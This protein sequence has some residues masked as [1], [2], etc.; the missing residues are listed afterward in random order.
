MSREICLET[1]PGFN[2]GSGCWEGENSTQGGEQVF[3][4]QGHHGQSFFFL[5][6]TVG[7]QQH[8]VPNSHQ[9]SPEDNPGAHSRGGKT[10]AHS[11]RLLRRPGPSAFLIMLYPN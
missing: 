4:V 3:W 11:S 8:P 9:P 2:L 5:G 7:E 10:A 1:A 6:V